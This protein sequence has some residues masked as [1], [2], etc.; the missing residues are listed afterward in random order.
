MFPEMAHTL[1][2]TTNTT[3][4]SK[5]VNSENRHKTITKN[6][7]NSIW[8]TNSNPVDFAISKNYRLFEIW[9]ILGH[10]TPK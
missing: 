10:K 9:A 4:I 1:N 5:L 3:I 8:S 6:R 7:P 2:F